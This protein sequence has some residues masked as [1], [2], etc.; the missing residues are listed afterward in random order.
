MIFV[1]NL[2]NEQVNLP[3]FW[4]SHYKVQWAIYMEVTCAHSIIWIIKVSGVWL[5]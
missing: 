2:K 5:I 1:E 3:L 4:E